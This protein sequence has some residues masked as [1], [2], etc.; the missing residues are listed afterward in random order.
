MIKNYTKGVIGGEFM[1]DWLKAK[2]LNRGLTQEQLA[3][4]IGI[5]RTTYAM[6]EQ[7]ERDPSVGVAIKIGDILKFNWTLFFEEKVHEMRNNK[8]VV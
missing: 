8:Q 7:G 6:Y 4:K 3:E 2:R 5:A 1:R